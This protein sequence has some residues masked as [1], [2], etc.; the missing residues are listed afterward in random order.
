MTTICLLALGLL[1]LAAGATTYASTGPERV[2]SAANGSV[3]PEVVLEAVALQP[4]AQAQPAVGLAGT[5]WVL[6]SLDGDLP[7]PDTTATL[8]FG[9][10][11]T[12]SGSDGCNQF[13]STY[14]QEGS[15][16]TIA[17][18]AASTMMACQADVM[19]QAEAYMAALARTTT[20]SANQRQL[21]LQEGNQ[22]VATFTAISQ[23]LAGTSWQVTAYN[24]GRDAAVSPIV[25]TDITVDFGDDARVTGNAGCNDFF[26]SFSTGD[27]TITIGPVATTFKFC[28][29]PPGVMEQEAEF[30]AALAS[31]ATYSIQGNL[32]ETRRDD[33]QLAVVTTRRLYVDLPEPP[34]AIPWGRVTAPRGLNVRSGPGVNFPVLGVARDGDEGEIIGRSADGGWWAVSIPTARDGIGWVSADF[35]LAMNADN[36]P[37]IEA[38]PPP[39][40]IPTAVPPATPTRVPPPT[41]T[42]QAQ[43]SFSADRTTINQGQC[44][45][46][47][48]SAQN[49]EAIWINPQNDLFDRTPHPS[50]GAKQVCPPVTTTY[51]MRVMQR[52]GSIVL[53]DVTVNVNASAT[54]A[55]QISFW[56][57]RTTIDRGEC[58]RLHWAVENVQAVW[59]YPQG[60]RYS[61]FPRVGHDSERVCPNNTTTYEMRVLLRDN[62]TEFRQVTINV[63]APPA[64][65]T[66]TPVADPLA[67]TSWNIVNFNNGRGG[68]TTLL[69]DTHANANFDRDGRVSGSAGCNNFNASYQVNG[70]NITIS[71]PGGSSMFCPDP[72]G[73]M[74]QEAEI[75]AALQSASTFTISGNRLEM[76][77]GGDQIAVIMTR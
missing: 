66:P 30:L 46:L 20:F 51:E 76:R 24:N 40:V 38:P 26:A 49:V 74:N 42:P 7:L 43:I 9:A 62:S 53:R 4:A 8:Q 63:N 22:I 5:N 37:V 19:S 11:G 61:R 75:L 70:N 39:V 36:V 71:P 28:A 31:A 52:D 45:I 68:V 48:W 65:P 29:E 13:S 57:D 18:P 1:A 21:T 41:A 64:P 17:Q 72:E 73:V 6:S 58:T 15:S 34:P 27:N 2:L 23:D 16:L 67:G 14:A 59:V 54:P 47:R 60:E 69:A 32:L 35:V 12:V 25:G 33:D 56:A 3:A 50:Q 77:T 44:T 10:D 55:P